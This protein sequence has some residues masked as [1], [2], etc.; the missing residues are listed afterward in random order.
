MILRTRWD[1][2][3]MTQ[4][5]A[6][7]ETSVT[8]AE[9]ST[10]A[11]PKPLPPKP[12]KLLPKRWTEWDFDIFSVPY[13][14]LP[15]IAYSVLIA[16]PCISDSSSKLNLRKLWRYVCAIA[17][18]YHP[19]PFHNFRHAVDVLLASSFLARLIQAEH[20]EPFLDPLVVAALLVSALVHDTDHPGVMS[21]YLI[22]TKHP[23]A[24]ILGETPKAVLE[25]HHAAMAIKLLERPE[26]DFLVDV[27]AGE[28]KRFI[29][30][31][32]ENVL[33]TDVTTTMLAAKKFQETGTTSVPCTERLLLADFKQVT[34]DDS[35]AGPTAEQVMCLIIK[36]ADISNPAR[37]LHV[38]ER[39]IEGAMT[40]FFVQGDSEKAK[41]LPVS[42]NCDRDTVIT[43]KAQ[44]GF[45]SFL[46]APLYRT[47]AAYAPSMQPLVNQ[48]DSNLKHFQDLAEKG[49]ES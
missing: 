49:Q 30:Q 10:L 45:I 19:R 16:H 42:M 36:A 15:G 22:A 3:V 25:H 1:V 29:D 47:L 27:G 17:A 13:D 39:W 38:Y 24:T 5:L 2:D 37:P 4:G 35:T 26:L 31:I 11:D 48:L 14:E 33:N 20:P 8:V 34:A 6:A 23:V 46:V 7:M 44:V 21:P 9:T 28:K 40:E 32:R 12:N 18:H 41:G 43:S